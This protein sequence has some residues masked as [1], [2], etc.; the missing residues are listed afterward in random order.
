MHINNWLFGYIWLH[1][2]RAFGR[3]AE[4]LTTYK[5]Q[6]TNKLQLSNSKIQTLSLLF[7]FCKLRLFGICELFLSI[8]LPNALIEGVFSRARRKEQTMR[9]AVAVLVSFTL[10]VVGT[11]GTIRSEAPANLG[12]LIVVTDEG[13]HPQLCD[14]ISVYNPDGGLVHQGMKTISPGRLAIGHPP[15]TYAAVASNHSRVLTLTRGP[16]WQ[17]TNIR[18]EGRAQPVFGGGIALVGQDLLVS[19]STPINSEA[20]EERPPFYVGKV[21]FHVS[22]DPASNPTSGVGF[23]AN[24]SVAAVATV[25]ELPAPAVEILPTKDQKRAWVIT[26]HHEIFRLDVEEMELVGH[27][28]RLSPI[29][30]LERDDTEGYNWEFGRPS[31]HN[32]SLSP[33][34]TTVV[35]NRWGDPAIAT[36][37]VQTGKTMVVSLDRNLL[38]AGGV[39]YNHAFPMSRDGLLA[40][41]GGSRV[42]VGQLIGTRF[43][44]IAEHEIT[45]PRIS[46]GAGPNYGI[47]WSTSGRFVSAASGMDFAVFEFDGSQLTE[48]S[49]LKACDAPD[50]QGPND[51]G[52]PELTVPFR[53]FLPVMLKQE[54]RPTK[55]KADVVLVLDASTSMLETTR[56][57]RSKLAA[58]QEAA[59]Q[60]VSHLHDG[61][62]AAIVSFNSEA[63]TLIGLTD[64]KPLLYQAVD[65]IRVSEQTRIHLGI[66]SATQLLEDNLIAG[67]TRAMI[68]LTDGRANPDPV[69]LAIE[70]TSVAK[71][72]GITI[73]VVALGNEVDLPALLEIASPGGFRHAPDGDDLI[74]IYNR[75]AVE[76]PCRK[77][78]IR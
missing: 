78:T 77:E 11:T 35:C 29:L 5:L 16:Q 44:V 8:S 75:I 69:E 42:Q 27:P 45:P 30:Y 68:V 23:E 70:A 24:A 34:Q 38:R 72:A 13:G 63:V 10:L 26:S 71:S 41:H 18:L 1:I 21:Q 6:D 39:A 36:V 56:S 67:N 28:I 46:W 19:M 9:T 52:N 2:D 54:C 60:F 76:I 15:L 25:V 3:E 14:R 62:R 17:S 50:N 31:F 64:N 66:E 74:D 49:A 51:V 37:N 73:Y 61:D 58:A 59:K 4:K 20:V 53:A 55:L 57:G 32:C 65:L 43:E 33:D 48:K 7:E 47:G 22:G 12:D 40:V